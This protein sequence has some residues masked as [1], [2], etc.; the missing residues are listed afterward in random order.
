MPDSLARSDPPSSALARLEHTLRHRPLIATLGILA[1]V[2]LIFLLAPGLDL[3]VSRLFYETTTGFSEERSILQ[4]VREAGIVA[5]WAFGTAVTAPLL[6]KVLFPQ[7][8]LPVPPRATLFVLG[9]F[10]LA[11]G[12]IVNGLLKAFWGRARP[13]EILE[14]GGD[15]AFSPAWWISDQ[16]DGNCS[17]VSG[18][19]SSAF[20]LVALTF[21]VR[22]EWR[23]AVAV[24]TTTFAASVSFT[25]IAM[26]GHFLSDVLIAWLITLCVMVALH[27]GVLKGLPPEF[28]HA[29]ETR[30]A[31]AGAALRRLFRVRTRPP[32]P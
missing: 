2:S 19:A 7:M 6:L 26:G 5:E 22:K 14:F 32:T 12:L 20:C 25:R 21:L 8:R 29:V 18:E 13:R 31:R 30:A 10:S 23:P 24:A 1:L 9:T 17:F 15:T 3:A 27:R 11:P 16:C 4:I 28:D